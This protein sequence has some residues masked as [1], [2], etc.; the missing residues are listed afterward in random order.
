M[1][2]VMFIKKWIN[3][4]P[5]SLFQS[6]MR[7]AI[8]L[9]Y[10]APGFTAKGKHLPKAIAGYLTS[11][12]NKRNLKNYQII[13]QVIKIMSKGEL[14][15]SN[16]EIADKWLNDE[17]AREKIEEQ[18]AVAKEENPVETSEIVKEVPLVNETDD[19]K[20][21]LKAIIEKLQE[22]KKDLKEKIKQLKFDYGEL[23][24]ENKKIIKINSKNERTIG[25]LNTD[26]INFNDEVD[27]LKNKIAEKENIIRKLKEQNKELLTFKEKA[28]LILCIGV[29]SLD[30]TG[31]F[32]LIFEKIWNDEIKEKYIGKIFFEIWIIGNIEYY[33]NLEIKN[34]FKCKIVEYKNKKNVYDRLGR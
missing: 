29:Q 9:G 28:P 8:K 32:N 17:N 13:V 34:S 16:I 14:V 5:D 25:D 4:I 18:L 23:E 33:K 27:L 31:G 6:V 22:E 11:P 24:K 10:F 20:K 21:E 1:N 15:D 3:S 30:N 2:Q 7:R 19:E 26:I 12:S